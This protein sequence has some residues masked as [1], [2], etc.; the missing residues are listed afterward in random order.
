LPNT[1]GKAHAVEI[2]ATLDLPGVTVIG[3]PG[4]HWIET[5]VGRV[6]VVGLP[7]ITRSFLLSREE[8]KDQP[9]EDIN[10]ILVDKAEEILRQ[11]ATQ[12]DPAFPAILTVHGSVANAVLSS[13]QS[14]MMVGHDPIIPLGALTNPAWD[15]VALG[16]IH[17]HQDLHPGAQ[18]PVVYAGS[19]ERIDFGEEREDKGVVWAQV[20]K[21]HTTYEFIPGPARRF[22]TLRLDAQQGDPLQLLDQALAEHDIKEAVVR[23]ILTVSPEHS[24]L[25]DERQI[26]E[27]L[28]EAYLLAG[29]IK[30]EIK[31]P[32]RSRDAGLT[33]VL[34][35]LQAVERYI[36]GHP[37]YTEH[38]Q[39]LLERAQLLLQELQE[40]LLV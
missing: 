29:I 3:Q 13:E 25:I 30:E 23:V 15:Y 33:E 6:Q 2:F 1:L 37:E 7:Y 17:R 27:R 40:E 20:D 24:D 39:A 5:A 14:I 16:H 36:L 22:V 18:P 35:P 8:Y 4:L 38:R 11:F 34:G 19:I 21:G 31:A 26:R 32:V 12:V 10:R 28:R 9:I